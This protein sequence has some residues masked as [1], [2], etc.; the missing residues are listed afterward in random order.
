MLLDIEVAIRPPAAFDDRTVIGAIPTQ[1]V[2]HTPVADNWRSESVWGSSRSA[3]LE[4]GGG[5]VGGEVVG[6]GWGV[7]GVRRVVGTASVQH[8]ISIFNASD[9][10]SG[11]NLR[12][13][14]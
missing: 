2:N 12:R 14:G 5:G 11:I 9:S 10:S 3:R 1:R 6:A 7:G 13:C 8:Q 4:S